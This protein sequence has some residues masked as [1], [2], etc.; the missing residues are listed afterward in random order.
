MEFPE[1]ILFLCMVMA[2]LVLVFY[3]FTLPISMGKNKHLPP[4]KMT[5][6]RVFTWCGIFTGVLWFVA[7]VMALA[8]EKKT[9][10]E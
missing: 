1:S 5:C 8:Y 2:V 9:Q 6:I 4:D 10:D 3:V 7:L